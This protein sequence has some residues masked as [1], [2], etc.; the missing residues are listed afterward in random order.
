MRPDY[1]CTSHLKLSGPKTRINSATSICAGPLSINP[2]LNGLVTL[3]LHAF[4]IR[5]INKPRSLST[6]SYPAIAYNH[7]AADIF[8]FEAEKYFSGHLSII[9]MV[10]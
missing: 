2:T 9:P 8:I 3:S 10:S 1:R 6:T 7:C 5:L 4:K